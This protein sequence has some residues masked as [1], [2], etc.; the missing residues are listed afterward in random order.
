[1]VVEGAYIELLIF[2]VLH[3]TDICICDIFDKLQLQVVYESSDDSTKIL[4]DPV[5]NGSIVIPKATR[6][7]AVI[8]RDSD[9]T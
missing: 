7:F 9:G 1:M 4:F 3:L 5:T 8:T 2:G 6:I